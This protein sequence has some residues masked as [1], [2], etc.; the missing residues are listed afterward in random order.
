MVIGL[1]EIFVVVILRPL[2]FLCGGDRTPMGRGIHRAE[3][4]ILGHLHVMGAESRMRHELDMHGQA[5]SYLAEGMS[6]HSKSMPSIG[7][8]VQRVR[9]ETGADLAEH[10]RS[11]DLHE[12]SELGRGQRQVEASG[13]DRTDDIHEAMLRAQR[14]KNQRAE[15]DRRHTLRRRR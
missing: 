5:S 3:E 1:G 13:G 7:D 12:P 4:W 10:V 14:E 15:R 9:T 6:D 8:T 11:S 2:R